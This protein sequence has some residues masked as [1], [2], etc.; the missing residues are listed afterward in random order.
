MLIRI[1]EVL[2]VVILGE[3]AGAEV[4]EDDSY[5]EDIPFVKS[6]LLCTYLLVG[7]RR[8]KVIVRT[9]SINVR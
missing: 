8:F 1:E 4:S 5:R 9:S 3:E 2:L 6:L 7:R